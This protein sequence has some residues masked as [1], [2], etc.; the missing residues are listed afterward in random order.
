MKK[1]LIFHNTVAPYRID[2]FN[3]VFRNFNTKIVL[4]YRNLKDQKFDYASIEK[5][6]I[7]EPSYL[8]EWIQIGK[9]D[10]YK[11]YGKNIK[12]SKPDTIFVSE[13]GLGMW[14]AI[15]KRRFSR[16]KYKI[17]TICDDSL[18]IAEACCGGR[19]ISRNLA[20]K[21]LDGII[22]CNPEVEDWYKRHFK[23]NTY[24]FPIIHKDEIIEKKI[25]E[26][27]SLVE[28]YIKKYDLLGYKVFVFVGR[29]SPEKNISY[30]VKSFMKACETYKDIKLLLVG[31]DSSSN[32]SNKHSLE[33]L[34]NEGKCDRIIL[35]GR[36]EGQELYAIYNCAQTLVLPSLSEPFGAVTNEAL[37]A[38][39]YV[40]VSKYA[41]SACLVTEKNGE[42]INIDKEYID[43]ENMIARLE[44]IQETWKP[45]ASKMPVSYASYMDGLI[46]WINKL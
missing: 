30:L 12:D 21:F 31:G 8:K 36:K 18:A 26:S 2:F 28:N 45:R 5:Q 33:Q 42:V 34:I 43:F 1:V 15:V 13:Y 44:P 3:D 14:V 17:I 4:D 10:F 40:M 24:M 19:K 6:F 27:D 16:Q 23:V 11:G 25:R 39:E 38:G 41:G 32:Q 37:A 35:T 20:I 7:F 46:E 9:R 22:L 29:L